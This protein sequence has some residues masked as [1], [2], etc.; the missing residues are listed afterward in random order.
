MIMKLNHINLPVHDVEAARDFMTKYFGLVTVF[1]VGKNF[2]VMQRDDTGLL[3]NL[4]HFDKSDTA[5][6]QY[7][8]DFHVG[9][10]V[11]TLA[12]VDAVYAQFASD[13]LGVEPPKQREGRYGFY[14]TAPGGFVV[15]VSHMT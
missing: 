13:G 6:V 8:R 7:H 4:S 1:E 5:E 12:E 9:F 11:D 14:V 15:E 3:L 10:F 2:L